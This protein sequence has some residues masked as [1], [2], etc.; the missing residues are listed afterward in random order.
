MRNTKGTSPDCVSSCGEHQET[1]GVIDEVRFRQLSPIY[2]NARK[3]TAC[4][5]LQLLLAKERADCDKRELGNL[6]TF[7]TSRTAAE[8]KFP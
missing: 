1:P 7:E 8:D 5:K 4:E 2:P 3:R 6:G